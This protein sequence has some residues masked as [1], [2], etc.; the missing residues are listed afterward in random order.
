MDPNGRDWELPLETG[1]VTWRLV[2]G[3][4]LAALCVLDVLSVVGSSHPQT[5]DSMP[6]VLLFLAPPAISLLLS[7]LA[8]QRRWQ[9]NLL[10]RVLPA[11]VCGVL[12]VVALWFTLAGWDR[13][14]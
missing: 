13:Y 3:A 9:P 10:F 2:L 6:F 8:V 14:A 12:G 5:D 7:A 1:R 11:V 4:V